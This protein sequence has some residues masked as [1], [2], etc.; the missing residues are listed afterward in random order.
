M[1]TPETDDERTLKLAL[2]VFTELAK[3]LKQERD[4]AR[5][6]YDNLATEHMLAV[7]KLCNERDE[8]REALTSQELVIAQHK[9]I[10]DLIIERNEARQS[11]LRLDVVNFKLKKELDDAKQKI[12]NQADRI[13]YLEGAINHAEGTPLSVALRE[14]DEARACAARWKVEWEIVEARLCGWK[15]PRD[16]GIIFEHEIIPKL[17]RERDE[18]RRYLKWIHDVAELQKKWT[19]RTLCKEGLMKTEKTK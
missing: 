17:E 19:I 6:K 4:E 14:R 18:A 10:T 16:N 15:H 3:T 1:S 5:E 13:R 8:A 12:K 11:T 9:V 2:E 7:N